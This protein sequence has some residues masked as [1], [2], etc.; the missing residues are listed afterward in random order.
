MYHCERFISLHKY[1][2]CDYDNTKRSMHM[3]LQMLTTTSLDCRPSFL[4]FEDPVPLPSLHSPT[5]TL[6]ILISHSI[7]RQSPRGPE[8]S[9]S[10]V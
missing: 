7:I 4:L 5:P 2:T 3:R 8:L 10:A 9:E 6:W 1:K